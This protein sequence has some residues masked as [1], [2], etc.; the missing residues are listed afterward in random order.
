MLRVYHVTHLS[1]TS[2]VVVL[3]IFGMNSRLYPDAA[4]AGD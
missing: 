4:L 3:N 2:S 1:I